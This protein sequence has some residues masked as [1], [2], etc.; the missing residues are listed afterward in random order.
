M[1]PDAFAGA[2]FRLDRLVMDD[3]HALTLARIGPRYAESGR[4]PVILGHGVGFATLAY[5]GLWQTLSQ[6]REVVAVDLRGH[7]LN[8]AGIEA[9]PPQARLAA[10]QAAIARHLAAE[11]GT[12]PDA[13][14]HSYSGVLSL[15]AEQAEGRLYHR[16]VFMEPPLIPAGEM[17]GATEAAAGRDFMAERMKRRRDRF[18]R[19]EDFARIFRERPEFAWMEPGAP[20]DLAAAVLVPAEEGGFRLACAPA[21]ESGFYSGNTPEGLWDLLARAK[22]APGLVAPSLMIAG[23]RPAGITADPFTAAITP[24]AARAGGFDL[25]QLADI[26][27]MLPMERSAFIAAAATAFFDE[28]AR[29]ESGT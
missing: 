25:L 9:T 6:D 26:T 18:D 3:G 19:L 2:G 28:P 7:G 15:H 8:A 27:H 12:P 22:R 10:D 4:R 5:R 13:L 24:V 23:R 17:E 14:F 16:R 21:V 11:A 1:I 29:E 20:D